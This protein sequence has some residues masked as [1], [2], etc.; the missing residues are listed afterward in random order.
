MGED[1]LNLKLISDDSDLDDDCHGI[2]DVK[3]LHPI[4]DVLSARLNMKYYLLI[5]SPSRAP[6]DG[7]LGSCGC[8][9]PGGW[10]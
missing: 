2:M 8:Y 4:G 7:P 6:G 10:R 5:V 9:V 3:N 1:H